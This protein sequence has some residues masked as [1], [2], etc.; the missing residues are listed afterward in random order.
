MN[1]EEGKHIITFNLWFIDCDCST[2]YFYVC[3]FFF[4]KFICTYVMFYYGREHNWFFFFFLVYHVD[5]IDYETFSCIHSNMKTKNLYMVYIYFGVSLLGVLHWDKI[6]SLFEI[7]WKLERCKKGMQQ[8][9][10][11]NKK[12]NVYINSNQKYSRIH[13]WWWKKSRTII[14]FEILFHFTFGPRVL[15]FYVYLYDGW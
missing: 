15:L 11:K 12:R 1:K 10:E 9:K 13:I 4:L 7:Q 2:F 6:R 5:H 3:F 14:G 8:K